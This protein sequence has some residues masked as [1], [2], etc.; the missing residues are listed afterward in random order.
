MDTPHIHIQ[1]LELSKPKI[2]DSSLL[3]VVEQENENF[4]L[5]EKTLEML[6]SM[7]DFELK[8][9]KNLILKIGNDE[10]SKS[11]NDEG[12]RYNS[13]DSNRYN[14]HGQNQSISSHGKLKLIINALI[15]TD[16]NLDEIVISLLDIDAWRLVMMLLD[17]VL[18][19]VSDTTIL[20]PFFTRILQAKFNSPQIHQNIHHSAQLKITSWIAMSQDPTLVSLLEIP[21]LTSPPSVNNHVQ[22]FI[23]QVYLNMLES[24]KLDACRTIQLLSARLS[25]I[26]VWENSLDWTSIKILNLLA[27]KFQQIDNILLFRGLYL[28][29]CT[30]LLDYPSLDLFILLEKILARLENDAVVLF[31]YLPVLSALALPTA[32]PKTIPPFMSKADSI[33]K[34]LETMKPTRKEIP[35]DASLAFNPIYAIFLHTCSFTPCEDFTLFQV[36][37]ALESLKFGFDLFFSNQHGMAALLGLHLTKCRISDVLKFLYTFI[38]LSN[39]GKYTNT[40]LTKSIP[41][42]SLVN[43]AY[44]SSACLKISKTLLNPEEH[45]SHLEKV[46]L[47]SIISLWKVQKRVFPEIKNYIAGWVNRFKR[48]QGAGR[49]KPPEVIK[50]EN[51]LE[52]AVTKAIFEFCKYDPSN[53]GTELIPIIVSLL[54]I[55][56]NVDFG[57]TRDP[58]EEAT[59]HLLSAFIQCVRGG[60]TTTRTGI[61]IA[62]L[63]L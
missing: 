35:V 23:L 48:S 62:Q 40:L 24:E 20:V 18:E 54:K 58:S 12:N 42:L 46:G 6:V 56:G 47:E 52:I 59:G 13:F 60:V 38:F 19:N 45:T 39:H 3:K 37:P 32:S 31:A 30:I 28:I 44:V 33:L 14:S 63:P 51:D 21:L 57:V 1:A 36:I 10:D 50:R 43:D 5:L 9:L 22:S 61:P 34:Q 11:V 25:Y 7:E 17:C 4:F 29:L 55:S 2:E 16:K 8:K 15:K 27:D 49:Q 53:C 41:E 26:W